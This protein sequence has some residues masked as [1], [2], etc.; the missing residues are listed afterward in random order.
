[1]PLLCTQEWGS[2]QQGNHSQ[3]RRLSMNAQRIIMRKKNG[4]MKD[5]W[6]TYWVCG[7][8]NLGLQLVGTLD[9]IRLW[10]WPSLVAFTTTHVAWE[11]LQHWQYP[12]FEHPRGLNQWTP[13]HISA[14]A[15]LCSLPQEWYHGRAP[16]LCADRPQPS[17][18]SK[19]DLIK[20][21]LQMVNWWS[22]IEMC[23][24]APFYSQHWAKLKFLM[25]YEALPNSPALNSLELMTM[26]LIFSSCFS[27]NHACPLSQNH[28]CPTP[29]MKQQWCVELA[30]PPRSNTIA[31]AF[32][33]TQLDPF[34]TRAKPI[35]PLCNP[36][37]NPPPPSHLH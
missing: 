24:W 3:I 2:L 18:K 19:Y 21:K 25:S 32:S 26:G 10:E 11:S 16:K 14:V 30:T 34:M 5:T 7:V 17:L 13:P 22:L 15:F 23:Q 35:V 27:F 4:L 12:P 37:M 9:D 20:L 6:P 1:M 36:F 28:S 8:T 33:Q 31:L 29:F